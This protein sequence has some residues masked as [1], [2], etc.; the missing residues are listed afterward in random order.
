MTF[1]GFDPESSLARIRSSPDPPRI[2]TAAHSLVVG[3]IGFTLVSLVVFASWAMAGSWFYRNLGELGAYLVWA[4]V[5]VLG[6]GGVFSRLLIGPKPLVKFYAMFTMAFFGYAAGWTL[7][8]FIFHN[9]TGEWLGSL[10]GTAVFAGV[11]CNIFRVRSGWGKIFAALFCLHSL[12]YFSGAVLYETFAGATGKLLW[13]AAY[14]VGFG[15]GLAA[16]FYGC[17][18]EIRQRLSK[19]PAKYF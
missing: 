18:A 10:V 14:G 4:T 16:A 1:F 2:P 12:G 7:A 17:Q 3:A 8:W 5:F 13:G 19:D 11:V 6:A 9:K 15:S